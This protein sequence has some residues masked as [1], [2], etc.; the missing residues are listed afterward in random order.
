MTRE[1]KFW[2]LRDRTTLGLE[3]GGSGNH[4]AR[5]SWYAACQG[6]AI[7]ITAL[8]LTLL[9]SSM[10]PHFSGGQLGTRNF[11]KVVN[12]HGIAYRYQAM[13]LISICRTFSVG[14][15]QRFPQDDELQR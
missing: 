7:S 15:E 11:L 8:F 13:I 14:S 4:R 10:P 12:K 5:L 2:G 3:V 9:Y 6:H 1:V